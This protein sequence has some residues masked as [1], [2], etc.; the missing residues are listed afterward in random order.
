MQAVILALEFLH[1]QQVAER[2]KEVLLPALL[3]VEQ[4]AVAQQL[5]AETH[6]QQIGLLGGQAH[7]QTLTHS[8][9]VYEGRDGQAEVALLPKAAHQLIQ[10]LL[11]VVKTAYLVTAVM[12]LL[13]QGLTALYPEGEAELATQLLQTQHQA[14]A[15]VAKYSVLWLKAVFLPQLSLELF[16]GKK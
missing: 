11:Q 16:R 15:L 7:P 6:K 3:E 5:L 8:R 4:A 10:A 9:L 14:Q 13:Q 1:Y 2:G 12:Q